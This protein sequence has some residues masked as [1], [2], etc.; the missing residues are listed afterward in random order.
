MEGEIRMRGHKRWR[1]FGRAVGLLLAAYVLAAILPY[2]FV[3]QGSPDAPAVAVP[4]AH[5]QG[6]RAAILTTGEE[7]LNAR[8]N[9]IANARSSLVVGTYLYA[10]DDSGHTIAAA[11]LAAA[12]RGVQVRLV[13]DGMIGMFNLLGSDLGYALG[14]HPNIEVRFYN[15]IDLLSPWGLSARYHEKYVMADDRVFVLGGR[16]ISDE[17]LTPGDHPKYN[18]DMDVLVWRDAPAEGS[19]ADTLLR[20]FDA[21][22]NERC[23]TQFAV[24]PEGRAPYVQA[25][26]ET[27][28]Q[29]YD[30]LCVQHAQS[31][32]PTDWEARTV[33]IEGCALLYNPTDA[34]VKQPNVW[35]GLMALMRTAKERVWLQTPYLVLNSHMRD[36]LAAAAQMP[37][38]TVIITN[39]RASGNNIVASADAVFHRS[40]VASMPLSL[41]EFQGDHSMHTKAMVVDDDISVFGSF[42]FDMRSAYSDTELMLVIQ[43]PQINSQLAAHMAQMRAQSLQV[44]ADGVYVQTDDAVSPKQTGVG[45]NLIVCL[46]SPFVSLIRFLI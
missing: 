14:S 18:Y 29:R 27:L 25:L 3:P 45:K 12:D 17:F 42:N 11:L 33:P 20:Y 23:Q 39:S 31:M 13:T 9:L 36:S 1:W 34:T 15:P 46:L 35:E 6:D 2:A 7:A 44:D 10:D 43:S 16:N 22:W 30:A 38:E 32:A 40:M 41:Y 4:T 19:A 8:L 37:A 5:A 26:R 28:K 24:T 21:L